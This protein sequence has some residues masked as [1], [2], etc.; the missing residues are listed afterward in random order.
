MT[1]LKIFF[2]INCLFKLIFFK[3]IYGN[4]II[5]GKNF[6]FRKGFSLIIDGKNAKVKIGNGVFFNNF[7]TI[8]A[9]KSI[10]IG[11]NTIFGENVKIYDHNHQFRNPFIA[12]KNQGYASQEI[13]IGENCWI[14]SHVVILKGVTIGNHSIIGAGN[15]VYKDVP[16]NSILLAVQQ[17]IFKDS[18]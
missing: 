2:K 7:C 3:F 5:F 14:A 4:K 18:I 11:D 17:Q 15:V 13:I 12:I 6:T 16:E 9:M 10:K 1:I 8:A